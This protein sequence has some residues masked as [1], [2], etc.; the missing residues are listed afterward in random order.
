[1][2][3]KILNSRRG[4]KIKEFFLNQRKVKR[5]ERL[6]KERIEAEKL[7]NK[8]RQQR[9][10]A[11]DDD[12]V[13]LRK[14]KAS[15]YHN[16]ITAPRKDRKKELTPAEVQMCEKLYSQ[17][18]RWNTA[19]ADG[20][21]TAEHVYELITV[22]GL[23]VTVDDIT[24]AFARVG[25]T[26]QA[27][28]LTKDRFLQ[29]ISELKAA[30]VDKVCRRD[31]D[32]AEAYEALA[33]DL[34][35]ELYVEKVKELLDS[36]G[37]TGFN[38]DAQM[39]DNG[40]LV[41]TAEYD[42][43]VQ[44]EIVHPQPTRRA[45]IAQ[46][47]R[48]LAFML[49]ANSSFRKTNDGGATD[50]R[51]DVNSPTSHDPLSGALLTDISDQQHNDFGVFGHDKDEGDDGVSELKRKASKRTENFVR[52]QSVVQSAFGGG[53]AGHAHQTNDIPDFLP[54]EGYAG[55]MTGYV[56][57]DGPLGRGYYR[58]PGGTTPF[59]R[60]SKWFMSSKGLVFEEDE[61]YA[62]RNLDSKLTKKMTS[63]VVPRRSVM[64]S[65]PSV[66]SE[67][68]EVSYSFSGNPEVSPA[69]NHTTTN[70]NKN[71]NTNVAAP[72]RLS[73]QKFVS[74]GQEDTSLLDVEPHH[75]ESTGDSKMNSNSRDGL[76]LSTNTSDPLAA[77]CRAERAPLF[78][79]LDMQSIE[80][81]SKS[82][83]DNVLDSSGGNKFCALDIP[84]FG[85]LPFSPTLH[86]VAISFIGKR[87][88]PSPRK[89]IRA[90]ALELN[91][92]FGEP[93]PSTFPNV[94]S[95]LSRWFCVE[96]LA[97]VSSS[98]EEEEN[99]EDRR[100]RFMPTDV[101]S[102]S[103]QI[104]QPM[105]ATS[106]SMMSSSA[107]ASARNVMKT[108]KQVRNWRRKNATREL[109]V[110][111]FISPYEIESLKRERYLWDVF[112]KVCLLAITHR[113]LQKSLSTFEQATSLDLPEDE[114]AILRRELQGQREWMLWH[115]KCVE[116]EEG[117]EHGSETYSVLLADLDNMM[118]DLGIELPS[119]R[120]PDDETNGLNDGSPQTSSP[121][122]I[123]P[124][125]G[126]ISPSPSHRR[127]IASGLSWDEESEEGDDDDDDAFSRRSSSKPALIMSMSATA[128]RAN[129]DSGA[130]GADGEH[131]VVRELHYDDFARFFD[132]YAIYRQQN[133]VGAFYLRS[134][135]KAG[136]TGIRSRRKDRHPEL[137][138]MFTV[139]KTRYT[140]DGSS[141]RSSTLGP[142]PKVRIQST[143]GD[144][145]ADG[146]LPYY[147]EIQEFLSQQFSEADDMFDT[148]RNIHQ[149]M[150]LDSYDAR[151][152]LLKTQG[153]VPTPP[154]DVKNAPIIPPL[155]S[156]LRTPMG[157][158]VD[159]IPG[160]KYRPSN[161]VTRDEL[162]VRVPPSRSPSFL[163]CE[164]GSWTMCSSSSYGT[165]DEFSVGFRS[166]RDH[167]MSR[168]IFTP[169]A[170]MRRQDTM[171]YSKVTI[172]DGVSKLEEGGSVS[173]TSGRG[174]LWS[175]ST[176]CELQFPLS[177]K[178][179]VDTTTRRPTQLSTNNASTMNAAPPLT[180]RDTLL[181][182]AS[183]GNDR[184][185]TPDFVFMSERL[186]IL[187][188]ERWKNSE[189]RHRMDELLKPA[190]QP[191]P[192]PTPPPIDRSLSSGSNIMAVRTESTR[193]EMG[194]ATPPSSSAA[195]VTFPDLEATCSVSFAG[196]NSIFFPPAASA[197][198]PSSA[199]R[200]KCAKC[201]G[202][203]ERYLQVTPPHASRQG[204][205]PPLLPSASRLLCRSSRQKAAEEMFRQKYHNN[206]PK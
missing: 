190:Q 198:S 27:I 3:E 127:Q 179:G 107:S 50:E 181:K 20:I 24:N 106:I 29:V 87:N 41:D 204:C 141:R 160:K 140:T 54:A 51:V 83:N 95:R 88:L 45:T 128:R 109:E 148:K 174:A 183:R 195:V 8:G 201:D 46:Q 157:N 129:G 155:G 76:F 58:V 37:L 177:L 172:V 26:N 11:D 35:A 191:S 153:I 36:M 135:R 94:E 92:Y 72:R 97:G 187:P 85:A 79:L 137:R 60:F 42:D 48:S 5:D 134:T 14:S 123:S 180:V 189:A 71:N 98:S 145:L 44:N 33:H 34:R 110:A 23:L 175:P 108:P 25:H 90:F 91:Q 1:M 150:N 115:R 147:R 173:S 82:N 124:I 104:T 121:T 185:S 131:T 28:P 40:D 164:G 12:D 169:K 205:R 75:G 138:S 122:G 170:S 38:P 10:Q 113:R 143:E 99:P 130:E 149:T 182:L 66:E 56:Y 188:M 21:C 165:D 168:K 132:R 178:D 67:G 78:E 112:R 136:G 4:Q 89:G 52:S 184:T 47:R 93:L 63:G 80:D 81:N 119:E 74:F 166:R 17:T 114:R 69:D 57:G 116:I 2:E 120:Q 7:A 53:A 126:V 77:G 199:R 61:N 171:Q 68:D 162:K 86:N 117:A 31:A 203:E 103:S 101:F 43:E 142:A 15:F 156:K 13:L 59:S 64:L 70:N 196:N 105:P 151:A 194:G 62:V 200:R 55:L 18:I 202:Q 197:S 84:L 16:Y 39:D 19:Y 96:D 193:S 186:V 159:P 158:L 163:G 9:R 65:I 73:T 49:T 118:K 144:N 176:V 6:A 32:I 102:L 30:E 192:T 133:N 154:R 22:L 167:S 161:I 100:R 146:H 125:M 206:T 152:G 111:T 139:G